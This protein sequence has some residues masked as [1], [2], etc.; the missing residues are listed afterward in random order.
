MSSPDNDTDSMADMTRRTGHVLIEGKP[1]LR[2]E[3]LHEDHA[4]HLR[5]LDHDGAGAR[6]GGAGADAQPPRSAR[7]YTP[8]PPAQARISHRAH[9]AARRSLGPAAAAACCLAVGTAIAPWHIACYIASSSLVSPL[10]VN[11]LLIERH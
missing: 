4:E 11:M 2:L 7:S 9:R 6:E 3:D 10:H 5:I 1:H 8:R